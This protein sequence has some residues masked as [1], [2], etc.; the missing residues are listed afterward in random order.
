MPF[1]PYQ[2]HCTLH[3]GHKE[4]INVVSFSPNG[5]LLASG[6][7]DNAV[8]LWDVHNGS[9]LQKIITRSPVLSFAWNYNQ[10]NTLFLG[11]QDGTIYCI[12]SF[13]V[14]TQTIHSILEIIVHTA[15]SQEHSTPSLD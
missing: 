10:M 14:R 13:N 12:R 15:V 4:G 8:V 7:D 5:D 1:I 6:A 9:L 11:C 3:N 2:E